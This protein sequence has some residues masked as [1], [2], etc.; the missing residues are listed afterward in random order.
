MHIR[1]LFALAGAILPV[2]SSGLYTPKGS[3]CTVQCGTNSQNFTGTSDLVCLDTAYTD[4]SKGQVLK[5]CISCLENSTF[6]SSSAPGMSDQW[7]F[8]WHIK[9]VQQYCL[10]DTPQTSAAS[11]C[12]SKCNSLKDVLD[13]SW[14]YSGVQPQYGYCSW[15]SSE[16]TKN[17][18]NC[19]SCLQGQEGGVVIGNFAET[20]NG[21]CADKPLASSGQMVSVKGDLFASTGGA[22]N[23]SASAS[24][25]SPTSAS[26]TSTATSTSSSTGSPGTGSAAS[27]S[28]SA[29]GQSQGLSTGAKAGIGI[30]VALG[31][32][33][34]AGIGA[35]FFVRR[36]RDAAAPDDGFAKPPAYTQELQSGAQT[37]IPDAVEKGGR[38]ISE[39]D[40][41]SHP[42]PQELEATE[43]R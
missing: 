16:Y 23:T 21:A 11:N 12:A 33:A 10:I 30:G 38:M 8:L 17:A 41:T 43:R 42:P 1:V 18:G 28:A 35:L 7:W 24:S 4:T 36:K 15:N 34:L 31:V 9:Y 25:S 5:S 39:V 3:S 22:A 29:S 19:A 13:T 40:A 14:I 2:P 6:Y 27:A 37:A 32:I 20:L 26:A